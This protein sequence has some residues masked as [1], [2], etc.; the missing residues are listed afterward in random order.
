[1]APPRL[2]RAVA[3]LSAA[4]A[5]LTTAPALAGAAVRVTTSPGLTPSFQ[6]GTPD[7]VSRC[8]PGKP[9]HFAV[10]ATKGDSVG[11][12]DRQPRDGD[13]AVDVSLRTGASVTVRVAANGRRTNHHVRCLPRDFPTWTVR[14][15]AKPES[16]WYVLTP[17]GR[18]S[19]GYVAVF[20]ARGVPVWWMHSSWYA[21]WDGKLMP[22]GNLMWSRIFGTDFGLS[23]S[24]GWEE[25]ALDG[26]T[27]RVL[28]TIGN[29][30][31]FHDMEETPEGNYLLDSYRRRPNVNLRAFGGPRHANVY[32][33]EIQELTPEGKRVWVWN[34]RNHIPLSESRWWKDV[35][36]AQSRRPLDER[37]Y[38]AVHINSMEP[39]GDGIIVSARFLDAVFRIDRSTKRIT[40]KLGGK[41]RPESL[42]VI[43]DPLGKRPLGGNHDARLYADGTVTVYDNGASGGPARV[44]PPRA[45]RYRIDTDKHTATLLEDLREPAVRKSGWG[46]GARKLPGGNWVMNWGATNLTTERTA[47]NEPVLEIEFGGDKWGYRAF[48][49]PHGRLSA[50]QLRRGMD[51]ILSANRGEIP[52]AR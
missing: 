52:P 1:M 6:L 15:H 34:S 45:V 10:S 28:R 2:F 49:I 20:D 39:D 30:T 9:L 38:D 3:S 36:T 32:D 40:W 23:E 37:R 18:Y 19:F 42:K 14:R 24:G 41:R 51:A 29:P 35:N 8:R 25:H 46:G 16:Q 27:V 47:T 50:Q 11:I 43:G 17:V 21:P 7:Y 4:V 31:D 22:S 13:F 5:L 26:R 12:G 44:R 33:A 48:P